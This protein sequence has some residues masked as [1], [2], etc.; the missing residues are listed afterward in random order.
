[1]GRENKNLGFLGEKIAVDF[2]KNKSYRILHT[3]FRTPF[4]EIDAIART[5]DCTVFV[6]VKTRSTDSLGPP[7]LSVTWKKQRQLIKN[8]LYY[9]KQ[10]GMVYSFWRIDVIA[11]KIDTRSGK[12]DI[13]L[14][15]NAVQES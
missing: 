4:G 11:V 9:L 5:G 8:A 10:Y 6:E 1:M 13:E 3:N 2:L 15:E 7:S 12:T 14:I